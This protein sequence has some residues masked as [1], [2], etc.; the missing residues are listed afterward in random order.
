MKEIIQIL[1]EG[2]TKKEI[3]KNYV[4]VGVIN[5]K[6]GETRQKGFC[7]LTFED[8]LGFYFTEHQGLILIAESLL[9]LAA[10]LSFHLGL[11]F[12]PV[13]LIILFLIVFYMKI[14]Y[15]GVIE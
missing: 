13:M 11:T 7:K 14:K 8:H 15:T 1:P 6:T 4:G 9:F 12:F 10:I 3:E 5:L 2:L